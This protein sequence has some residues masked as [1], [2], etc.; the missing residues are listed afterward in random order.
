LPIPEDTNNEVPEERPRFDAEFKGRT[1]KTRVMRTKRSRE[2]YEEATIRVDSTYSST[3]LQLRVGSIIYYMNYGG[4]LRKD[5][6]KGQFC[7]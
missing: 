4:A 7:K 3:L 6:R 1:P 2:T 5:L